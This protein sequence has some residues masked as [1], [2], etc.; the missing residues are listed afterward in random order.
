MGVVELAMRALLI[1][2]FVTAVVGKI[3]TADAFVDYRDSVAALARP[4]RLDGALATAVAALMVV[5][6]AAVVALLAVPTTRSAGYALAA[7][8]LAGFAAAVF[9][10]LRRGSSVRC[11]CFG[12]AGSVLGGA[13]AIRNVVLALGALAGMAGGPAAPAPV[14]LVA[15]TAGA[16]LGLVVTRW[17]D[18]SYL[19]FG[20]D[21]L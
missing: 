12:S 1:V 17:D 13:H 9:G 21:L 3:H 10:A 20:G 8:L 11:R 19:I 5:C 14:V 7:A 6:E 4:V 18:L 2:V 15:L 16:L